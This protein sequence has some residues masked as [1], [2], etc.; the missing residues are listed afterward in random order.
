[1]LNLDLPDDIH[2]RLELLSLSTGRTMA[3]YA[4]EAI[5]EYLDEIEDRYL[6]L[7]PDGNGFGFGE[8][9]DSY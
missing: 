9:S 6:T 8:Q 3:F 7:N 1:M 2:T 5:M 4:M